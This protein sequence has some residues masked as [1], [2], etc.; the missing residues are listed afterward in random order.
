M[1]EYPGRVLP[2]QVT[3]DDDDSTVTFRIVYETAVN[4]GGDGP[5]FNGPCMTQR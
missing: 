3:A 2:M 5:R 1:N 4:P